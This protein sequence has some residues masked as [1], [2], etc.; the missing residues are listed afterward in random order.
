MHAHA[1][2]RVCV[3]VWCGGVGWAGLGWVGQEWGREGFCY[4]YIKFQHNIHSLYGL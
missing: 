2:V 3:C 4:L 1:C